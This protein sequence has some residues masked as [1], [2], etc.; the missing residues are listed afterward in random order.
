MTYNRSLKAN[1]GFTIVELLVVV[2]VIGILAA[3]TVV[4]Y[5]A[6]TNSAKKQTV[7]TDALTIASQLNKYKADKGSY[8][9]TLA[10]LP[11]SSG[12]NSTFQYHY[13]ATTGSFC[14]TASVK[15]ASAYVRSGSSLTTEGGCPG[16]GLNGDS[17]ITN[18]ASN[19]SAEANI[20]GVTGYNA[21]VAG[22][23]SGGAMSGTYTFSTTTDSAVNPQ[24]L[25]HTITTTAK[26]NQAYTCSISLKGSGGAVAFSGRPATAADGYISESLGS[27]TITLTSTWQRVSIT[28]TTPAT[29]GILR[30]QYRLITAASGTTIQSD[31]LICTEGST[32][33]QFADGSSTNWI[34]NGTAHLSS[35]TG[36]AL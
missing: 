22:R 36:P 2:V 5:T 10:D 19:P 30:V 17:P 8:P 1:K 35:S 9:T 29:T 20:T 25:I 6:V 14:L 24:G 18:L 12:I 32:D 33:Y 7:K 16:D 11:S 4:S 26:P 3:I 27:K 23:T 28:F 34:W 21:A 31:A 13:D 15:G